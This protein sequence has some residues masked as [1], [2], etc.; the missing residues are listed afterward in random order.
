M[1]VSVFYNLTPEVTHHYFSIFYWSHKPTGEY[2]RGLHRSVST[3]RWSHHWE[4]SWKVVATNTD[5]QIVKLVLEKWFMPRLLLFGV[6]VPEND[7]AIVEPLW[8]EK[9]VDLVDH[10][11]YLKSHPIMAFTGRS[12]CIW[13]QHGWNSYQDTGARVQDTLPVY[14]FFFLLPRSR[15]WRMRSSLCPKTKMWEWSIE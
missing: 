11:S 14:L 8:R 2:E 9:H 12:Y 15:S 1:E 4:C 7:K 6:L 5:A 3:R 10:H 13:L